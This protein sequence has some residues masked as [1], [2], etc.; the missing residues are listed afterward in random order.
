MKTLESE[1]LPGSQWKTF[2]IRLIGMLRMIH[3]LWMRQYPDFIYRKNA[4]KDFP[5]FTFHHIQTTRFRTQLDF[6]RLNGYETVQTDVLLS[7][8]ESADGARTRRVMLTFDDGTEDLY[9]IAFPILREFDMKAVA[10]ISPFWIDQTGLVSWNQIQEMHESGVI[11]FQSHSYS[12]QMIEVG[13]KIVDFYNPGL[14][15]LHRWDLPFFQDVKE[16][17]IL[18]TM[19]FG[20]PIRPFT[21]GMGDQRVLLKEL[22]FDVSFRS[23]VQSHGGKTFFRQSGWSRQLQSITKKTTKIIQY[24]SEAEQNDRIRSELEKSKT[25]IEARLPGKEVIAFA[26]P[27]HIQGR[28]TSRLLSEIGYS[29]VFG[30]IQ[31]DIGLN[32]PNRSYK[33]FKRVNADFIHCL[34]GNQSQG[35]FSVMRH[36]FIQKQ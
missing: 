15:H 20:T 25:E 30:G 36:K 10:F 35:I 11:D 31:S 5:V 12:H 33:Y 32:D 27:N 17:G 4:G 7:N 16:S 24:E 14:T 29:L 2:R 8:P 28:I 18:N 34:T 3:S 1:I 9:R 13:P 21:S 23:E 19:S 22:D 6:I 26:Y